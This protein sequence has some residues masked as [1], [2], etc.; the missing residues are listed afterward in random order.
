MA[1]QSLPIKG[2]PSKFDLM[3]AVFDSTTKDPRSVSFTLGPKSG[4]SLWFEGMEL[5]ASIKAVSREDDSGNSWNVDGVI[6]SP[7]PIEFGDDGKVLPPI[8]GQ[9]KMQF[10]TDNRRGTMT[11]L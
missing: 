7:V 4:S 11:L 5:N 1:P 3:V 6:T 10:R 8:S 2:G 9:F